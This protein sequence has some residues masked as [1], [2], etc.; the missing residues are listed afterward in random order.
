MMNPLIQSSGRTATYPISLGGTS[1][2][3]GN[4]TLTLE[5]ACVDTAIPDC[6]AGTAGSGGGG[7]TTGDGQVI[8]QHDGT[9]HATVTPTSLTFTPG[10]GNT[11]KMVTV[12]IP[13]QIRGLHELRVTNIDAPSDMFYR[14]VDVA[15]LIV[16]IR[17]ITTNNAVNRVNQVILPEVARALA[18]SQMQAIGNRLHRFRSGDHGSSGLNLG[19]QSTVDGVVAT[20]MQTLADDDINWKRML[21][22][23]SFHMPLA[24]DGGAAGGLGG[25]AF[26]GGGEYRSLGGDSDGVDWDGSITGGHLG[27]DARVG[28]S[29]LAGLLV[30]YGDVEIDDYKYNDASLND[31][32]IEGDWTLEMTTVNP[33][34]GWKRGA[35]EGWAM[36]GFGEGDLEIDERGLNRDA[37]PLE[38]D[39]SMTTFGFGLSGSVVREGGREVRVK[40]EAFSTTAEVDEGD[41][42]ADHREGAIPDLEVD[43]NRVRVMVESSRTRSLRSGADFGSSAEVGL[44]YD[45]G[46]GR[47]G[48]G[49]ELGL[50]FH[51]TSPGG[52]SVEG[53]AR[54]LLGHRADYDDWGVSGSLKLQPGADG[55]GLSLA[56]TPA[57]GQTANGAQSMWDNGLL[58]A[59]DA[60]DGN[61]TADNKIDLQA[62]MEVAAGYG[63]KAFTDTGLLTPYSGL[64]FADNDSHTVKLGVQW[65]TTL[66]GPHG[67]SDLGLNLSAKR[68]PADDTFTLKGE[69]KF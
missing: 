17:A 60:A 25:G 39:V 54:G 68:T 32:P 43:A 52:V 40:A 33:Y 7:S 59:A 3:N 51:Y 30:H 61:A 66:G 20:N 27:F 57:Y 62:R 50:G 10:D 49:S 28:D 63:V 21:A 53:R 41:Y 31:A 14:A 11:A 23:S 36:A 64:T 9:V 65:Q 42:I 5:I 16:P 8:N 35:V 38:A 46:D 18:D 12:D 24:G 47:T 1:T 55:Q 13:P 15:Q 4:V 48:G 69:L 44:R 56:L 2:R 19:G 34:F 58:K 67:L 6:G 37:R 22:D 29:S 45:G 26:Y